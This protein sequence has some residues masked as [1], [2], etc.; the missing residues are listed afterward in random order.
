MPEDLEVAEPLGFDRAQMRAQIRGLLTLHQVCKRDE[1]LAAAALDANGSGSGS[2]GGS[3]A[4][5][6]PDREGVDL[7]HW[8]CHY[9]DVLHRLAS[10]DRIPTDSLARLP[11][12]RSRFDVSPS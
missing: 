4:S 10:G 11:K 5:A 6:C 9:M 12:A 8:C 3:G 1:R 2:G 7:S